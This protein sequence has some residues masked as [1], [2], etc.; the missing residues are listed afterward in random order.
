MKNIFIFISLTLFSYVSYADIYT[1]YPEIRNTIKELGV[2]TDVFDELWP[3]YCD[4]KLSKEMPF[5]DF[6]PVRFVKHGIDNGFLKT[7]ISGE[8]IKIST[9]KTC[10]ALS[11]YYFYDIESTVIQS[12]IKKDKVIRDKYKYSSIDLLKYPDT[13]QGNF[14]TYKP[15]PGYKEHIIK[16]MHRFKKENICI[17][18]ET[19][20]TKRSIVKEG[21]VIEIEVPPYSTFW[22]VPTEKFKMVHKQLKKNI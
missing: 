7:E 15:L 3:M 10:K 11:D 8:N 21:K 18:E 2:D 12:F 13:Y 6:K 1:D 19:I 9:G 17:V 22:V 5:K 16:L 14:T 20:K 4:L